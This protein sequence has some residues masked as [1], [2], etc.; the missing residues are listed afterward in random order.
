[1]LILNDQAPIVLLNPGNSFVAMDEEAIGFGSQ[2]YLMREENEE[3][4]SH[5][6]IE[7]A[8]RFPQ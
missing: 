7:Y 8:H 2:H 1:M 6:R 5:W 3:D 4:P